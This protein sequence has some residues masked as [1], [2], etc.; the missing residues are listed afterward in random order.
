MRYIPS[1][2]F[3]LGNAEARVHG[4]RFREFAKPN[5]QV[6]GSALSLV[7]HEAHFH[8]ATVEFCPEYTI[9]LITT[10]LALDLLSL[11]SVSLALFRM[12]RL[13]KWCVRLPCVYDLP[14]HV[15]VG[16]IIIVGC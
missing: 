12:L 16:I 1:V 14:G 3:E 7:D 13:P 8:S 9:V 15:N 5:T 10:V 4:L 11:I 2:A 6:D